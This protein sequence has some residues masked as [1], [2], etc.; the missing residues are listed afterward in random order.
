MGRYHDP[1][2]E[3]ECVAVDPGGNVF[4]TGSRDGKIVVSKIPVLPKTS[5][6]AENVVSNKERRKTHISEEAEGWRDEVRR[7][8]EALMAASSGK[9][10]PSSGLC[11][12]TFSLT[13]LV[14]QVNETKIL[15]GVAREP[16]VKGE[17]AGR[18][19]SIHPMLAADGTPV[20]QEQPKRLGD[21]KTFMERQKARH[22]THITETAHIAPPSSFGRKIKVRVRA[23]SCQ[24]HFAHTPRT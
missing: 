7:K 18:P 8:K 2:K 22:E 17:P 9:V 13:A 19:R 3:I 23:S 1:G 21:L 6:A 20:P 5:E 16:P 4:A 14:A 11:G 15:S 24:P 12:D 10:H